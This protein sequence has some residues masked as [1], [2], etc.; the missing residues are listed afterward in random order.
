MFKL[1]NFHISK[2]L[3]VKFWDFI[4]RSHYPCH[5]I[6]R[7][8]AVQS[9]GNISMKQCKLDKMPGSS[10]SITLFLA[11]ML[12]SLTPRDDCKV[13]NV[14]ERWRS[15][16][17]VL[18]VTEAR[19]VLGRIYHLLYIVSNRTVWLTCRKLIRLFH[20][21]SGIFDLKLT[22]PNKERDLVDHWVHCTEEY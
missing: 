6:H 17:L 14:F 13:R 15:S 4:H 2:L 10:I 11:K 19:I 5:V 1:V 21:F 20:R 3:S 12:N 18:L 16:S 9:V 7:K 22:D 8:A